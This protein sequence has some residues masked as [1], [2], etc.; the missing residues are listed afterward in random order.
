MADFDSFLEHALMVGKGRGTDGTRHIP[1]FVP[2]GTGQDS[3][4]DKTIEMFRKNKFCL[5]DVSGSGG[6]K[7]ALNSFPPALAD[8]LGGES[9]DQRRVRGKGAGVRNA[10]AYRLWTGE[11][12]AIL[13]EP[14]QVQCAPYRRPFPAVS[15]IR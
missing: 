7:R 15:P 12:A 13:D 4:F 14:A 9:A 11:H 5:F 3:L 2:S 8:S 10:S 6:Y 1:T